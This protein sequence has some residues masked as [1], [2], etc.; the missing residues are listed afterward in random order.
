MVTQG[1][2]GRD[3]RDAV[4]VAP[5]LYKV[6]FENERVRVLDVRYGPGVKSDMHSHPD[7]VVIALTLLKG[8]FTLADGQTVDIEM[9]PGEACRSL[10]VALCHK[11]TGRRRFMMRPYVRPVGADASRPLARRRLRAGH[12]F[13]RKLHAW[14]NAP[15]NYPG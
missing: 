14:G 8:K 12:G 1:D 5:H 9:Q 4:S 11:N 10:A 7:T 6:L 2:N 3:V 13:T 15:V